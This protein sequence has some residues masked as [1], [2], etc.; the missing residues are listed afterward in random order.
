M[1]FS[2]LFRTLTALEHNLVSRHAARRKYGGDVVAVLPGSEQYFQ[3][4]DFFSTNR[5]GDR[6]GVVEIDI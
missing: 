1:E 3:Y 4:L 6:V 2:I 5:D